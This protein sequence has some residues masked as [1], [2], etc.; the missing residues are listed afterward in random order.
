MTPKLRRFVALM[1]C[2]V[3]ALGA[4]TGSAASP[5]VVSPGE[6]IAGRTYS[7]WLAAGWQLEFRDPPGAWG[8][9]AVSG[10]TILF[11]NELSNS[12]VHTCTVPVGRPLYILGAGVE[13]STV[14]KP[15]FHGRTPAELKRCA[16]RVYSKVET[17]LKASV[18]GTPV[19]N[20]S[21]FAAASPVFSFHLPKNNVLHSRKRAGRGAGRTTWR[22]CC[23]GSLPAH[24]LSASRASSLTCPTTSHGRL[25]SRAN[26]PRL[27]TRQGAKD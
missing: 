14:E 5:T 1:A 26:R 10:V 21:R 9:Q 13:C 8:C 16:R 20:Y 7:Q 25:T 4:T 24:T 18:D 19:D 23:A 27:Q 3:G 11:R 12:E 15:P 17:D 6:K 22:C 2:A